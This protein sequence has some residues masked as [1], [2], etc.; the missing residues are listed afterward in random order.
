MAPS[1]G[2]DRYRRGVYVNVQRTFPYPMLKDFDGAD[3]ST[4]CPRRERSNTPLQALTM[5]N[6]PALAECARGLGLRVIREC[7]GGPADRIRHAF[8]V[9]L[10]RAPDEQERGALA[11]VYRVPQNPLPRRSEGDGRAYSV[12]SPCRRVPRPRGGRLGCRGAGRC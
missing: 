3:P 2:A 10:A 11:L 1:R 5:L 8:R 6:D 9:S 12:A 4:S 7:P